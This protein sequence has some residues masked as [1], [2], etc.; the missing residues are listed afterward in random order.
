MYAMMG[1]PTM[2]QAAS[3]RMFATRM[4]AAMRA[5]PRRKIPAAWSTSSLL[6]VFLQHVATGRRFTASAFSFSV[7][8]L[9]ITG[10]VLACLAG[11]LRIEAT[12]YQIDRP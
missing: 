10:L 2:T 8:D 1:A 3:T 6:K 11:L 12:E 9:Q 4:M 7:L 5:K